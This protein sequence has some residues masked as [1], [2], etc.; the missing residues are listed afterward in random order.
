MGALLSFLG[1]AV[2]R[3]FTDKVL[4]WI[5][6]KT[7]LVFLFTVI[8]PVIL[9]NFIYD[10]M[11]IVMNS[12]S[13]QIGEISELNGAMNFTGFTAWLIDCF[14][15]AES[16]SVLISALVLRVSLSMIPFVRLA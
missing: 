1:S 11:Q 15:L 4:G 5:A 2:G 7:I 10:I 14:K 6:L 12:A 9:N 16:L 8:V 13:G 3:V